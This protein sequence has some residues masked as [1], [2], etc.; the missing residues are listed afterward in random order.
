VSPYD[1]DLHHRRSIRLAG[2]DYRLEGAYFVTVCTRDQLCLLGEVADGMMHLNDVGSM[3]QAVWDELPQH[4]HGVETDA[5]V[6]MPNHIHGIVLMAVGG[7]CS[8]GDC[9]SQHAAP[10]LSLSDVI[11]RFKSLTTTRYR[12][13]VMGRCSGTVAGRLWHRNYYEHII[14]NADSLDRIR[15]YIEE[16]ISRW[17]SD[18]ENPMAA[19][20]AVMHADK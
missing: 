1:P 18:P 19:R 2:Y 16:N 12:R 3:V 13:A 7:D 9:S 6:V 11:Q 14:R 17:A 20:R 4:Y 15:G 5:F 10:R 8:A